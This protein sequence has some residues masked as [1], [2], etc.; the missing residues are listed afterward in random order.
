MSKTEL[1]LVELIRTLDTSER[2]YFKNFIAKE[3]KPSL[4][5]K[6][7]DLYVK[8]EELGEGG[9]KEKAQKTMDEKSFAKI[10]QD[11]F[12]SICETMVFY[13]K[14]KPNIFEPYHLYQKINFLI[15]KDL[16]P[17]AARIARELRHKMY[18]APV[19][20]LVPNLYSIELF[21]HM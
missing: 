10:K 21:V 2:K 14:N 15:S 19:Q 20:L 1:R 18:H 9:V 4:K 13:H 17:E 3:N 5:S 8:Y 16:K 7:F 6:V 11:L 12:H